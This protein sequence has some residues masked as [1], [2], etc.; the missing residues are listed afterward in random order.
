MNFDDM[1]EAYYKNDESSEN[2]L[3]YDSNY[4]SEEDK[5]ESL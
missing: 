5:L 1:F 4:G 2:E 3:G